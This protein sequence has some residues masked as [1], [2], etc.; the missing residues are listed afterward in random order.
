MLI[1][2]AF[3][4]VIIIILLCSN[5]ALNCF[6]QGYIRDAPFDPRRWVA[7]GQF[8]KRPFPCKCGVSEASLEL[9]H[10]TNDKSIVIGKSC[11]SGHRWICSKTISDC[12][13]A[14]IRAYYVGGVLP[15]VTAAMK[16]LGIDVEME[17]ELVEKSMTSISFIS[18]R[19]DIKILESKLGYKFSEKGL[20]LE[21]ITHASQQ[22]L[23][24]SYEVL[25]I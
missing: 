25:K 23:G 21:A 18:K 10:T 15:A 7:P 20:L 24:T 17:P 22:E 13:E 2:L 8:A 14:L 16:W 4:L 1:L 3:L 11:D 6:L 9:L 12:V 19:D 5:H